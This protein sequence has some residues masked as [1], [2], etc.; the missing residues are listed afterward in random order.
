MSFT[1][2]MGRE[3]IRQKPTVTKRCRE[4]RV[5]L[6]LAPVKVRIVMLF[7]TTTSKSSLLTFQTH[8]GSP[9]YFT[10]CGS[11][12][13]RSLPSEHLRWHWRTVGRTGKHE[14]KSPQRYSAIPREWSSKE[15]FQLDWQLKPG[16][17]TSATSVAFRIF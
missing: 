7:N 14:A 4:R 12:P 3:E 8:L 6:H 1:A 2:L 17:L 11:T 15:G 10:S 9:S 13:R 5:F 16:Y